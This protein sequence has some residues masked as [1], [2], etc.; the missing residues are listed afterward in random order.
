[1]I[2]KKLDPKNYKSFYSGNLDISLLA[3]YYDPSIAVFFN[4]RKKLFLEQMR[5]LEQKEG[6]IKILDVGCY[7]GKTLFELLKHENKNNEYWGVDISRDSILFAKAYS[8]SNSLMNF[9]FRRINITEEGWSKSLKNKFDL[10][11][12]S[13][14][15]EHLTS[16]DQ[17]I[18][19]KELSFLLSEEGRIV[20][21]CPNRFCLIKKI[22]RVSKKIPLL[23]NYINK[24]GEFKGSVGHLS[25]PSFLEL[26]KM[27]K[28]FRILKQGGITFTYGNE[29]I[30]NS[31]ILMI[32]FLVLNRIFRLFFPFW[33]FDQYIIVKK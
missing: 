25:E 1:M 28:D 7:T 9:H 20:I 4:E 15:I 31:M 24:I 19:L 27:V 29:K 2:S 14:V 23:R 8:F 11:I 12:F 32:I 13:E 10:I 18:V 21:T 22:L 17:K 30:G 5:K 16:E 3:E 6:K 26:K 33:A